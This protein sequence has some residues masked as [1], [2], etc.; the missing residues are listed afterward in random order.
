MTPP[1][2]SGEVEDL[3][4]Q[5]APLYIKTLVALRHFNANV[6]EMCEAVLRSNA[7]KLG[8]SIGISDLDQK[9]IKQHLYPEVET[10][11]QDWDGMEAYIGAKILTGPYAPL[12]LYFYLGD[13][14]DGGLRWATGI[15][16]GFSS[17]ARLTAMLNRLQEHKDSLA[18]ESFQAYGTDSWLL[19]FSTTK[20][21]NEID[22]FPLAL[23]EIVDQWIQNCRAVGIIDCGSRSVNG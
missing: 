11:K 4:V 20:S 19:D 14:E 1:K 3:F 13:E 12:I 10:A 15:S 17:K 9:P 23:E 5:G 2:I 6:Y 7:K 8:E 21:L 22:R 18:D 16:L